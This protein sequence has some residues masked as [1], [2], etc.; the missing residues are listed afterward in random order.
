MADDQPAPWFRGNAANTKKLLEVTEELSRDKTYTFPKAGLGVKA[1]EE[2]IRKQ[3]K[4]RRC[5]EH[6][7]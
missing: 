3:M 2:I 5:K 6:D 1:I 7:P 4:E